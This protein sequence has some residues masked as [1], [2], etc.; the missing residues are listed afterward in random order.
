MLLAPVGCGDDDTSAGA[1][2]GVPAAG[3]FT[4]PAGT[5]GVDEDALYNVDGRGWD[6]LSQS[7]RFE[8]ANQY[9]D[10]HPEACEGADVGE[11]VGWADTSFGLDYPLDTPAAYVLDEG[12]AAALAD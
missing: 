5:P 3:E 8:A 7:A 2:P 6:G 11:V 12:C 4:P 10:D 9:I 1:P